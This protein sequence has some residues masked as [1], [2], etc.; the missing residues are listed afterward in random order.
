IEDSDNDLLDTSFNV[1]YTN[2]VLTDAFGVKTP[3]ALLGDLHY[4]QTTTGD[5]QFSSSSQTGFAMATVVPC[6]PIPSPSDPTVTLCD[7]GLNTNAAFKL[8]RK[9]K[10][11]ITSMVTKQA[12]AEDLLFRVVRL[13]ETG[14]VLTST[15]L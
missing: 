15:T 5:P 1:T 13:D 2:V 9:G 7:P 14:G 10:I 12:V 4:A 11:R 6:T 8:P 3:F